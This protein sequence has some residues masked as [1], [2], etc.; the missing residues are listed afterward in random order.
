MDGRKFKF[1][2]PKSKEIPNPKFQ[3]AAAMPSGATSVRTRCGCATRG[4]PERTFALAGHTRLNQ[5]WEKRR[6][7]QI[8]TKQKQ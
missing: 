3:G 6:L 7:R 8:I 5:A 4:P 2:R 1:Q